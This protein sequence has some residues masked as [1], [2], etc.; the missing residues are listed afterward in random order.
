M[1]AGRWVGVSGFVQ[2]MGQI[3]FNLAKLAHPLEKVKRV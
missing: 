1:A 2:F 3:F